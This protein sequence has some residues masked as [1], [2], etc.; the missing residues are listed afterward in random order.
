M[1]ARLAIHC[2][3]NLGS[4][5]I[6]GLSNLLLGNSYLYL[7]FSHKLDR[8]PLFVL[9]A[10]KKCFWPQRHCSAPRG[11]VGSRLC[12]HCL[13]LPLSCWQGQGQAQKLAEA[14]C[15]VGLALLPSC[16]LHFCLKYNP[17]FGGSAWSCA[18][19]YPCGRSQLRQGPSESPKGWRSIPRGTKQPGT[20]G[21]FP[22][23]FPLP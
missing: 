23:H 3:C 11:P 15:R 12:Q 13:A 8:E 22:V 14:E 18:C 20:L 17:G 2:Q 21:F 6:S 1:I 19:A 16:W 7:E 5:R 10:L 9:G 4:P